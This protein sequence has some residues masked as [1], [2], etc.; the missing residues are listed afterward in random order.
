LTFP[1]EHTV[2]PQP[3]EGEW[4]FRWEPAISTEGICEY[5]IYIKFRN[6]RKPMRLEK[7]PNTFFNFPKENIVIGDRDREFMFWRI[8][9]KN[10][11][12]QWG[13]WSRW[14]TIHVR[15]HK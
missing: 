14:G 8:R 15:K 5:E 1:P 12:G 7:T 4:L 2:L 6:S 11:K 13:H 9:A 10:C 3:K